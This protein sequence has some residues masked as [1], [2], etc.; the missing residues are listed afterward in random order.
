MF[1]RFAVAIFVSI[2]TVVGIAPAASAAADSG[3]GH[4]VTQLAI[5]WD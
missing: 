5:D 4:R 3:A 1:K 2:V